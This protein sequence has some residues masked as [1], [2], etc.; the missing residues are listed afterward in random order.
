[1]VN[2]IPLAS[3]VSADTFTMTRGQSRVVDFI[4]FHPRIEV[5][6]FVDADGSLSTT[7]D[8]AS[9]KWSLL[10]YQNTVSSGNLISQVSSAESLSVYTP[11]S[12]TYIAVEADSA[13]WTHLGK[14]RNAIPDSGSVNADTISYASG[15]L[16]DVDFVNFNPNT[17]VVRKLKDADGYFGTAADRTFKKWNLSLYKGTVNVGHLVQSIASSESLTVT[18]LGNGVYIAVEADSSGWY[19]IGKIRNGASLQGSYPADT[20]AVCGGQKVVVDF[21]NTQPT[22]TVRKLMDADGN[23]NT[24]NDRTPIPWTLS[25]YRGSIAPG[26]VVTP[27]VSQRDS[28][29]FY[30]LSAGTYI[31]FES[32]S[33][34]WRHVGTIL[35]G[36]GNANT[37]DII[38]FNIVGNESHI[39]DFVNSSLGN[40]TVK[41]FLDQDGDFRTTG[42]R[43]S[44]AWGLKLYRDSISQSTVVDSATAASGLTESNLPE[45]TYIAVEADS[46]LPWSHIATVLDEDNFAGAQNYV[47][48]TLQGGQSRQVR[49]INFNRNRIKAWTASVDCN[50][51][52]AYNW[53]PPG[54]PI[55]GDSITIPD[56]AR[57][58]LAIP[59]CASLGTISISGAETVKVAAGSTVSITGDVDIQGYM[60]AD[61]TDTSTI[62]VCGNLSISGGFQ[63]GKSTIVFVGGGQQTVSADGKTFFKVQV[64]GSGCGG[65]GSGNQ[66]AKA[67]PRNLSGVLSQT[68]NV[69]THGSFTVENVLDLEQNLDAGTDTI[70]VKN[71]ASTAIKGPGVVIRGTIQRAIQ[72]GSTAAYRFGSPKSLVQ[73]NSSG[74]TPQSVT[75]TTNPDTIPTNYGTAWEVVNSHAD[76]V[77]RTVTADSVT[78]FSRWSMGLPR[79]ASVTP[80]VKRVYI[81]GAAGGNGF[82]AQLS[83]AY[84][85]GE[86]PVGIAEDSLKLMRISSTASSAS[87]AAGWNLISIPVEAAD[88][89]KSILF[90]G[91]P[92]A[93]AYHA[94]Y[95]IK[96]TFQTGL[97]YWIKFPST[98][99][100]S[101]L[102]QA[103]TQD[104]V[105]VARDWNIIGT[106]SSPVTVSSVAAQNAGIV[107][108]SFFGYR[109][110]YYIADTLEPLQGYWM[111]AKQSGGLMMNASLVMPKGVEQDSSL[112][113]FSRMTIVDA[114]G[115]Q[116]TLFF[117]T[118][119]GNSSQEVGVDGSRWELP[120]VPPVGVFDVRFESGRFL[121]SVPQ[122]TTGQFPLLISSARYPVTIG[123][124][125]KSATV[126]ASL[127]AGDRE[128][129]LKG[130][131]TT[132]IYTRQSAV[133]LT[134]GDSRGLPKGYALEQNYPNPFNPTTTLRYQLPV[135]SRVTL[136]IYNVLGQVVQTLVDGVESGGYK[137]TEWNASGVASGM[138]FYR[139]EAT[140]TSD[141]TKSFT[142]VKKM[143]LLK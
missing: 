59:P 73:F 52:N 67:E 15:Q 68:A 104:T 127:T 88:M 109:H 62:N 47:T 142:Q 29:I 103:R 43:V 44:K 114:V 111:K 95:T 51:A 82:M 136:K 143:L 124:Q 65:C 22:V 135:N 25:L 17:V 123:W 57:C 20:F 133:V 33:V 49:F 9:K 125:V 102:G 63:A 58:P 83:L 26:N 18:G 101:I 138:Y 19:H 38:T 106:L 11:A 97:G 118:Q 84:D 131:G 99:T 141:P 122:G 80:I 42:D 31:A 41:K 130:N 3:P 39:C 77:A 30:G 50:W 14:I 96:D 1:M 105:S 66:A 24:T 69:K 91:T 12:G 27:S 56:T 120:P 75:I 37:A 10:L 129:S 128:I 61:S 108:G 107:A 113:E 35:D 81:I 92:N 16:Y 137:S 98:Q 112:A 134:L 89:R 54:I 85:S 55:P 8:R 60:V 93:F 110:G 40:V 140:S 90:P 7:A 139:L 71:P 76:S 78:E 28:L 100:V 121:E 86:V 6:K 53:D 117:G 21:V 5:R 132:S 2:G 74:T 87:V 36:V 94:G 72:S 126:T 70:F 4:N 119:P 48:F 13:G 32:D 46:A 45:G 115:S 23:F 64:G 79:P 34:G 116:Q